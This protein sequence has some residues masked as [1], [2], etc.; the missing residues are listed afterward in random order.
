MLAQ[1][2]TPL[3]PSYLL[4][5]ARSLELRG[6]RTGS[7]EWGV[8][9]VFSEHCTS[10]GGSVRLTRFVFSDEGRQG[11]WK[12]KRPSNWASLL[13]ESTLCKSCFLN[14]SSAP[15]PLCDWSSPDKT[16]RPTLDHQFQRNTFLV[17]LPYLMLGYTLLLRLKLLLRLLWHPSSPFLP[18]CHLTPSPRAPP[19]PRP[20]LSDLVLGSVTQTKD[21]ISGRHIQMCPPP[22]FKPAVVS[23]SESSW[24]LPG[25]LHGDIPHA[26]QTQHLWGWKL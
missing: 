8:Y 21:F 22:V 18:Y 1:R 17:P 4:W 7:E 25:P 14:L 5:V 6:H 19:V 20:Q 24:L 23:L 12:S 11:G 15:S 2:A 13:P 9:R 16:P 10:F 26:S 3:T